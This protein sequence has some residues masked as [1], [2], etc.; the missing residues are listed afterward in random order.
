MLPVLVRSDGMAACPCSTSRYSY[1]TRTHTVDSRG[2]CF[3][4]PGCAHTLLIAELPY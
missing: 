3:A 2:R 1:S 4:A